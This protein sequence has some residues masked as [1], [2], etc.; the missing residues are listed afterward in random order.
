MHALRL[1]APHTFESVP[2]V[3]DPEP[4]PG[5]VTVRLSAAA[6]CGSDLAIGTDLQA[7]QRVLAMP[8]DEGGLAEIYLATRHGQPHLHLVPR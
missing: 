7:G 8:A 1:R 3:P 5:Q 6:L 4:V 2:D